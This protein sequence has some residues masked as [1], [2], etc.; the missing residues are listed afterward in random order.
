MYSFV[1]LVSMLIDQSATTQTS[2][3]ECILALG[4]YPSYS[5]HPFRIIKS[6]VYFLFSKSLEACNNCT[7]RTTKVL[8]A[9]TL[10]RADKHKDKR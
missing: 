1:T 6:F 5:K 7:P 10:G 4:G 3:S 8:K 9:A 2:M